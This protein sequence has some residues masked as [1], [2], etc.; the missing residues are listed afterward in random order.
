MTDHQ[1]P[2]IYLLT[3]PIADAAAFL[4]HLESALASGDV[5]CV[6]LDLQTR[7]PSEAKKIVRA[8]ASIVQRRDAA[9]LVREAVLAARAGADGVH[10]AAGQDFERD[11]RAAI[12]SVKPERIV[13]VGNVRTKHD[14]MIA[15][16]LDVD[17]LMFGDPT[18]DG[19]TPPRETVLERVAWWAEIFNAPCVAYAGDL[20][21]APIFAEA[22]ADFIA[23]GEAIWSDAR[24]PERAL[25]WVMSALG[26]PPGARLA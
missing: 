7:D 6:L 18:A 5:A 1:T 15:G 8:V 16:E 22:G 3:P 10:V 11:L 20:L 24:G 21:D 12:E 23:L 25:A 9:L 17:Y 19:W 14:A 26:K 4:P 13:G 2:R